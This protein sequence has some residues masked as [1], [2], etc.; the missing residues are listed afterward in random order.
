MTPKTRHAARGDFRD[1]M[2]P[3]QS[4]FVEIVGTCEEGSFLA[5]GTRKCDFT[6]DLLLRKHDSQVCSGIGQKI[7]IFQ[8]LLLSEGELVKKVGF[9]R[10]TVV[11]RTETGF[12][13]RKP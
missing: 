2:R 1:F 12:Y 7:M 5:P 9:H 6:L 10:S 4:E 8:F 13:H 11:A 3:W